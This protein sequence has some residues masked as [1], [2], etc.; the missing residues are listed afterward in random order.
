MNSDRR[1]RTR[2]LIRPTVFL[3]AG[4][5][6]L[7]IAVLNISYKSVRAA[8]AEPVKSLRNALATRARANYDGAAHE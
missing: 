6:A 4:F 5:G 1:D 3:M 2:T 8:F 7:V